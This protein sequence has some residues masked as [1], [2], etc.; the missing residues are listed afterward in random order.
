MN[1]L[2]YFI[3]S[4]LLPILITLSIGIIISYYLEKYPSILNLKP[5]KEIEKNKSINIDSTIAFISK[6]LNRD[7]VSYLITLNESSSRSIVFYKDNTILLILAIPT[8][9]TVSFWNNSID[10]TS[11]SEISYFFYKN[12]IKQK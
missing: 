4:F 3:V 1:N 7:S 10:S 12:K 11:K 9:P 2:K 8:A 5:N 6:T